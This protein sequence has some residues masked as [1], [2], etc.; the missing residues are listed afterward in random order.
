MNEKELRTWLS[1]WHHL[2]ETYAVPILDALNLKEK[3]IT[4]QGNDDAYK[5]FNEILDSHEK[6]KKI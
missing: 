3:G 1:R 4:E 5:Q 6:L 2:Y